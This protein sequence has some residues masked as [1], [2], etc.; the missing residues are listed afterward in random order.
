[1][2]RVNLACSSAVVSPVRASI[3]VSVSGRHAVAFVHIE[4]LPQQFLFPAY[5]FVRFPAW[6]D[7][8]ANN[9]HGFGYPFFDH[10]HQLARPPGAHGGLHFNVLNSKGGKSPPKRLAAD[11]QIIG[12]D[13]IG[14]E[15]SDHL[16]HGD[17]I[18]VA[19]DIL[20]LG[21]AVDN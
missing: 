14:A 3:S 8:R 17:S 11:I 10:G 1:M 21:M 5:F 18:A 7:V 4:H 9:H 20:N 2:A 19:V 12:V 13:K 16:F 15:F 6:R